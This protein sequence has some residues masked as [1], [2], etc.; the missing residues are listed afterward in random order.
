MD[1]R[2]DAHP[3]RPLGSMSKGYLAGNTGMFYLIFNMLSR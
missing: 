2:R 1:I 3:T